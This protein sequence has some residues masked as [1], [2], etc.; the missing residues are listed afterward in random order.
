MF[1]GRGLGDIIITFLE[2][3]RGNDEATDEAKP[4]GELA[5]SIIGSLISVSKNANEFSLVRL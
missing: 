5:A 4:I 1:K 2:E 3:T